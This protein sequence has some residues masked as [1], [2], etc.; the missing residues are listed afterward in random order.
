MNRRRS[1]GRF[2]LALIVSLTVSG[3]VGA[4]DQPQLDA[5]DQ[6]SVAL[7]QPDYLGTPE[8]VDLV[9]RPEVS[10]SD[11][12]C[13]VDS[14]S[15]E[16]ARRLRTAVGLPADAATMAASF[17]DAEYRCTAFG[18]PM[19]EDELA[20][21]ARV[22]DA[23]GELSEA[24]EALSADPTFGG[25]YFE[26]DTITVTS[27]TGLLGASLSP[28]RGSIRPVKVGHS[29]ASIVAIAHAVA[30]ATKSRSSGEPYDRITRVGVNPKS[31]QVDIGVQGDVA[32]SAAHFARMYGDAVAVYEEP[33][34]RDILNYACTVDDCGT[35]GG[36]ATNHF[37]PLERCTSAFVVRARL[38]G[39]TWSRYM[40]TAGHCIYNAGGVSNLN[41]WENGAGTIVWGRNRVFD[42]GLKECGFWTLCEDNDQGLFR[43]GTVSPLSWNGYLLG[44][45]GVGVNGRKGWYNQYVGQ[46]VSR[47]GRTSGLDSGAITRKWDLYS[48]SCGFYTCK[49]YSIVEV[50][51]P[52]DD[53][54]SGAGYL[55][56][57]TSE[58][59]TYR[60][61]Y[62][63]L[64][65]GLLG[66]SSPTFYNAWDN[67]FYDHQDFHWYIEP[68]ISAGC[69]LT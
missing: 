30:E 16:H 9:A 19:T 7:P 58:G 28:S 34:G 41:P 49:Y 46:I 26:G 47:N 18:V 45:T 25:A 54:D 11:E 59:T 67:V 62:G 29:E 50:D 66:G 22:L 57:Y 10:F 5:H 51:M 55:R 68:C 39:A 4:S 53:G 44:A 12:P 35:R 33:L 8:D 52:S 56:V 23:Q 38:S 6:T 43:L 65:G 40:L 37:N 31:N 21:Y 20:F 61:A 3:P 17:R 36:I 15:V 14:G 69:S 48:G 63:T 60:Q 42:Y 2:L 27:T 24:V 1:P 64:K 13:S 32:S